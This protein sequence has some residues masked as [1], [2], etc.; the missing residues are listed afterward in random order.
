M[1][2]ILLR[3]ERLE[4]TPLSADQ[5]KRYGDDAVALESEL[6]MP[7]SRA[8]LTP[9]VR[10]AIGMKLA[11]MENA[12]EADHIWYTYWL[13]VVRNVPF[14]AGLAGFK[15]CPDPNGETEIGYGIDPE[16]QGRGYM[17]EAVI[18]M[19]R[20]ALAQETCRTVV[21]LGV[22][23]SNVASQRVLEKAGMLRFEESKNSIS[24][25]IRRAP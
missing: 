18:A 10:R 4:L 8:I 23:P 21:A 15:G 16:Y 17:T 13:I 12:A 14:G 19:I 25:R 24:Y 22:D 7:I 2:R 5:L 20:W 9:R 3:T 6:R 11:K 1:N